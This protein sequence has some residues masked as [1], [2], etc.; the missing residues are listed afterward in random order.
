MEPPARPSSALFDVFLRL[1]PSHSANARFLT[2][3]EGEGRHPTHITIKPPTEDKR[4]RAI[5]RFAFTRVFQENAQQKELFNST[6]IVPMIEGVLGVPGHHGRDGLL[7]TLGVTGSGKS[8]TILGTKSQRGLVQMSLDVLFQSCEEQ[9]VQSFY[10]APAFSSLAAA[11]V[12]DAHMYTATA[13]LDSMYGDNQSERFPSRAQTP[14]PDTS[15]FSTGGTRSN[16]I[17]RPST[18]PQTPTVADIIIP[19]DR[20]AEY[21]IV[22]SMY[23]VYNDRIF[24]LLTGMAMKNKHPSVK[25]RALLFKSTEQSPE[26]KVV[27]GLT[28][29]ICGSFE[30]A[31]MVLETGL[32]ERKVAGTGSNAV[33]SRS[34]GF[35]CVEVKKRDAERKGPWSSSTLTIVDLAGSERA[36]NAKTAGA[37]LAEAGKI[38]ESLMYLGQC[39][40]MQSDNQDGSKNIVPFR[41]CKLTELLFSNSFPSSSR[42]THHHIHPQKS[43]MIVTADPQSD[44]NATSQIL[45]YSAL[46]R[47]VTV[48]RI[49]STTSTILSNLPAKHYAN[50]SGRS[51]PSSAVLEEL[52]AA[53]T[54]IARLTQEMEIFAIRLTEETQRRRAA[55]ASWAA[56]ENHMADLEQEIRDECFQELEAA[57]D[58]ERRRWQAVLDNEQDNQQAH[59]DSKIDIVIKATKAQMRDEVKVYEDPDPELRDR[60]DE[61]ERENEV[62]KAKLEA[63]EREAHG[64]SASPVKKM[65]VLKTKKWEDPEKTLGYGLDDE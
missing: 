6:G 52:D 37:T 35:F 5:E 17:P 11:D 28:K 32:M 23:E 60:V 1:R 29:I 20:T 25:R 38:N 2:V 33:S 4:K 58:Q 26:R 64:R 62:L 50:S 63:M 3:E 42:Q 51:T 39:M 44:F 59:L 55:E 53:N 7:A 61:L 14:M 48:P 45:R 10:G 27:A 24:D 30:E 13:F 54:E 21:A 31:M 40:Q 19:T 8:H 57:V 9:L 49:P 22:I 18:L 56:A 47:E 65:R 34:H 43:I 15:M 16:K 41:Q 36:R 46:A 12:A